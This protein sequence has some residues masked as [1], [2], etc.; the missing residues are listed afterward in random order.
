MAFDHADKVE[1]A[2]PE[3]L[4][5]YLSRAT[6]VTLAAGQQAKV[7]LDLIRTGDSSN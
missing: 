6:H 2:N 1:Y 5:S 7:T 3:V 4:Q